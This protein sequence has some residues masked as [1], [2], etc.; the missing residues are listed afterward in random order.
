MVAATMRRGRHKAFS[1][2]PE[3][4]FLATVARQPQ[5]REA[6]LIMSKT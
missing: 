1:A 4:S 2:K 3:T 6:F 5:V